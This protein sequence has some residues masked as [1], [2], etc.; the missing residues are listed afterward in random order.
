MITIEYLEPVQGFYLSCFLQRKQFGEKMVP[1]EE[2]LYIL[3]E[4]K[5]YVPLYFI[6]FL[7]HYGAEHYSCDRRITTILGTGIQ[8][9][10]PESLH[11]HT[12]HPGLGNRIEHDGNRHEQSITPRSQDMLSNCK[13]HLMMELARRPYFQ[14]IIFSLLL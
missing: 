4:A 8:Q 2:V 1:K 3:T 10:S 5:S 9:G 11:A 7:E 14:S 12:H 6:L 13:S